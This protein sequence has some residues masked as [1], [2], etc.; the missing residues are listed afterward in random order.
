MKTSICTC[1]KFVLLDDDVFEKLSG[2]TFY[3]NRGSYAVVKFNSKCKGI[4]VSR[5]VLE[6]HDKSKIVD[7]K[8]SNAHDNRRANLRICSEKMNGLNRRR[9]IDS[10]S[11]LIG[12]TWKKKNKK[13]CAQASYISGERK[14]IGLFACPIEAARSRDKFVYA[15]YGAFAKPNFP[16]DFTNCEPVVP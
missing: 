15:E 4:L 11:G 1:G 7:H 8:N 16:F 2:K 13:W 9:R 12:V 10:T 3:C 6:F 14:H 5:A